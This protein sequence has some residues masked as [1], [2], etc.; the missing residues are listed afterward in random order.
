MVK[1]ND[2]LAD[3]QLYGLE[4]TSVM[5]SGR[6]FDFHYAIFHIRH[7]NVGNGWCNIVFTTVGRSKC[8]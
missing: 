6:Q 7:C 5:L 3:K 4:W 2:L 8:T 1:S